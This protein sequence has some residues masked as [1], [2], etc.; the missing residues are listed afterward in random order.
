MLPAKLTSYV[1]FA[2]LC[3]AGKVARVMPTAAKLIL[4]VGRQLGG[5]QSKMLTVISI[6]G[7][8]ITVPVENQHLGESLLRAII[9]RTIPV[10]LATSSET[11]K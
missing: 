3:C 10:N 2:D 1:G 8:A 7:L 9:L 11:G 5:K 6:R 4:Q